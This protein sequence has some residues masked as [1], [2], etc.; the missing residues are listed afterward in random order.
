M[1]NRPEPTQRGER[2]GH[3]GHGHGGEGVG[4]GGTVTEV[5]PPGIKKRLLMVG[6]SIKLKIQYLI[7]F[8]SSYRVTFKSVSKHNDKVLVS[9][10]V[11]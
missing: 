10:I 1:H 4:G 3:D 8:I 6:R 5:T 9:S 2:S 11:V 7:I